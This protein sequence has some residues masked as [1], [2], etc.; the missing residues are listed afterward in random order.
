VI[1]LVRRAPRRESERT[2][3]PDCPDPGNLEDVDAVVHLAGASI[4]GRFSEGHKQAIESSRVE[5]TRRL[6]EAMVRAERPRVL[7]SA[8]AIGYYGRDRGDETLGEGAGRGNGFLAGV[9]ERWEEATAPASEAGLRV[10]TVR[11]GIVL[12]ARGGMLQLL[13]PIFRA[14]LGGRVGG[15][16]QWLSWID[17][18]DLT[19]VYARALVDARLSGPLNAVAP[20]PVRNS[21]FTAQLAH[22]LHRP[23]FVPVPKTA[24]GVVL[25][26]EGVSE[27]ACASQRVVPSRLES[28]GFSFRRPS[29]QAVLRYQLGRLEA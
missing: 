21:E 2:W 25:G 11:T 24:L 4:A 8:S 16:D 29:L 6:A 7:L 14:G 17:L 5:P 22:V 27:V 3:R 19:D 13:R 18:D 23:A 26:A 15:G 9:V 1:R 12:S 20:T 10:V 28:A